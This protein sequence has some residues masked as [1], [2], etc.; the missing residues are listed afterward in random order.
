MTEQIAQRLQARPVFANG[1]L[2]SDRSYMHLS[3]DAARPWEVRLTEGP[4][5]DGPSVVFARELLLQALDGTP[6]GEGTV[7]ARLRHLPGVRHALLSLLVEDGDGQ[8]LEFGLCDSTV[9]AFM[10]RTLAA[11]PLGDEW[12][13][14]DLDAEAAGLLQE[15]A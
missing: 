8:P 2:G 3:Y 13:Y 11:V 4:A 6:A 10:R 1:R 5:G 14:F 12:R 7:R 9:A 15:A